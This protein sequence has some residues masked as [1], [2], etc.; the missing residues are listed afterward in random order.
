MKSRHV[1][2]YSGKNDSS[3]VLRLLFQQSSGLTRPGQVQEN[4]TSWSLNNLTLSSHRA[5]ENNCHS[6]SITSV[7]LDP[8]DCCYLVAGGGDGSLYI[9]NILHY[10][11]PVMLHIGRSNSHCHKNSITSV[12]W[13]QDSGM[14]ISSS[15]DGVIKVWDTNIGK[16]VEVFTPGKVIHQ[17]SMKAISAMIAVAGETSH[18]QLVDLR[19]GSLAHVLRG[20]H[21]G[22]VLTLAWCPGASNVLASGGEADRKIVLWDVRQSK[23]YLHYLDCNKVKTRRR[24]RSSD[25][26]GWSHKGPVHG[27]VWS[28][29]GHYLISTGHDKRIRRWDA[30]FGRNMKTKF[31][32]I[33]TDTKQ[34]VD[35]EVSSGGLNDYLFVPEKSHVAMLDLDTGERVKTLSGHY[36]NVKCLRFNPN[37]LELYSGGKDKYIHIW[38]PESEQNEN[39]VNNQ[40]TCDNWSDSE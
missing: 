5:V 7:D 40:I 33:E 28:S 9:H 17:H 1:Q 22:Q 8:E 34:T 21:S 20:G 38:S 30:M 10:L 19:S 6:A 15:R 12:T 39:T 11:D 37:Q 2:G 26:A 23:S 35:L 27:L 16:P 14:F 3:S 29:C 25:L 24:M 18:V 31:P 4:L 13:G 32:E 36:S